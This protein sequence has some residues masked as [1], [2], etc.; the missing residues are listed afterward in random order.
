M[1]SK[2][3]LREE[4]D[5]I[6]DHWIE[7]VHEIYRREV[8]DLNGFHTWNTGIVGTPLNTPSKP[9]VVPN[10]QNIEAKLQARREALEAELE[11]LLIEEELGEVEKHKRSKSL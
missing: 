5:H 6:K 4:I 8:D 3:E 7:L 1:K 2:K 10:I 11:A 9:L